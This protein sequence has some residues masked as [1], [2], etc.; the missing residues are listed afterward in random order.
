MSGKDR[1]RRREGIHQHQGSLAA[2]QQT[3]RVET[4]ESITTLGRENE[5]YAGGPRKG[6]G[7]RIE[8]SGR[9]EPTE[10]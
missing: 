6:L 9:M 7:N 5:I 3:S 4:E 1:K 10:R 2:L 8:K